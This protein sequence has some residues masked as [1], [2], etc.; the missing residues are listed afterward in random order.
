MV[1]VVVYINTDNPEFSEVLGVFNQKEDAVTELL[2]RA[3]YREKNDKLTQYMR[4]SNEY[5]S[6]SVL[7]QK[8]EREMELVDVD[9]Y[10]LFDVVVRC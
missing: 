2:E 9:I 1:F 3:N 5:E 8:V 7:R 6:F 4:P 10:R